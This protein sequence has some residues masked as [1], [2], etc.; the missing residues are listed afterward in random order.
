MIIIDIEVLAPEWRPPAAKAV[1]EEMQ[2]QIA[3]AMRIPDWAINHSEA[4]Q[5][6]M[7]R[8]YAATA[9]LREQATQLYLEHCFPRF[10][11]E[12]GKWP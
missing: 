10:L 5:R 12:R 1:F 3:E 6:A 8:A 2:K 11:V 4:H 7:H 9:A